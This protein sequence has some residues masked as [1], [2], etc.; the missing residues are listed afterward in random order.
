MAMIVSFRD[1]VDQM[2]LMSDEVTACINRKT[3]EL[4]TLTHKERTCSA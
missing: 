1:V 2:A 4:I 3:G